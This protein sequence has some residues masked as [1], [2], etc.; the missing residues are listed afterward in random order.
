MSTEADDIIKGVMPKIISG[1]RA[2]NEQITTIALRLL[3]RRTSHMDINWKRL[4]KVGNAASRPIWKLLAPI[5]NAIATR[6]APPVSVVIASAA[7]PSP[8][9][10]LKPFS[11]SASESCFSGRK[12]TTKNY[13]RIIKLRPIVNHYTKEV[14]ITSQNYM[15]NTPIVQEE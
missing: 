9:T 11:T 5:N 2:R 8:I 15:G 13:K 6:K 3:K 12:F 1:E 10:I 4:V 14:Y 7:I